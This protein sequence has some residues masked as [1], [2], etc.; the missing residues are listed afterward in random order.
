[1]PTRLPTIAI[2]LGIVG[3]VPFLVC[4]VPALSEPDDRSSRWVMAL[5]EY[6][7]VALA[8]V[9]GVQ[10]GMVLASPEPRARDRLR[11]ALGLLASLIGWAGLVVTLVL[12]VDFGLAV[13]I[14]G[15]A[16]AVL[17]EAR[18]KRDGLVPSGYMWLRW[19]QSLVVVAILVTVLTVRLLHMFWPGV[20]L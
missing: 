2:A 14:A 8:L 20:S 17:A 16:A 1:M 7:A 10:W 12:P 13:L 15:F 19:G 5:A 18:L 6:G 4:A 9:G 3:L 11:L